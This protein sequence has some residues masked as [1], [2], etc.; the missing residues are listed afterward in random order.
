[1]PFILFGKVK[2]FMTKKRSYQLGDGDVPA[3]WRWADC[4][5]CAARVAA[6]V[7]GPGAAAGA[8]MGRRRWGSAVGCASSCGY[9][10]PDPFAPDHCCRVGCPAAG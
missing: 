3:G 7:A 6:S 1:M 2:Y 5:G 10:F 9:G 8:W 4:V